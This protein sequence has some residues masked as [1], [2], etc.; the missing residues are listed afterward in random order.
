MFK[1]PQVN[2]F[3]AQILAAPDDDRPRLVYA[4][5]LMERGDPLGELIAVQCAL[6]R[7]DA[8]DED[9][10]DVPRMRVRERALLS[11]HATAWRTAAG[12][13]D[14]Q[15]GFRR[16]F[17]E[18]V[19]FMSGE[20]FVAQ[21]DML[22]DKAPLVRAV[23]VAH[24]H[25]H[26]CRWPGATRLV[27][28]HAAVDDTLW[29]RESPHLGALRRFGIY[30]AVSNLDGLQRMAELPQPI[31][32]LDV[33]VLPYT[34]SGA[35]VLLPR[36]G[37]CPAR[38]TLAWLRISQLAHLAAHVP[39][40]AALPALRHVTIENGDLTARAIVAL[41]ECGLETL[42]VSATRGNEASDLDAHALL[43]ATPRLRRLRLVKLALGDAQ[44]IAIAHTPNQLRRLDLARNAITDVGALA[45]A[46]SSHQRELRYLNLNANRIGEAARHA[47]KDAFPAVQLQMR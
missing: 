37:R 16:G 4:D 28:L 6:A 12:L 22:L 11:A 40:L 9:V 1:C 35:A 24:D 8:T 10:G 44:A 13:A 43:A 42:D 18:D 7:H 33:D 3:I 32:E 47:L 46:R 25:G 5:Y 41:A 26:I 17:I 45:L 19:Y 2:D 23:K 15:G 39:A 34:E 30:R 31:T 27:G 14:W 20:A 38:A 29:I 36:L 21:A